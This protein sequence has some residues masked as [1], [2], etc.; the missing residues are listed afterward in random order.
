MIYIS[1]HDLIYII[2][3]YI[4]VNIIYIYVWIM[5]LYIF[6]W[7]LDILTWF[8][9]M[10]TWFIYIFTWF[11][12]IY[13]HASYHAYITL[14]IMCVHPLPQNRS[15]YL[16]ICPFICLSHIGHSYGLLYII[17]VGFLHIVARPICR[18]SVCL[19]ALTSGG[20]TLGS[21]PAWLG[22]VTSQAG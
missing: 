13:L 4:Y 11:I 20:P 9:D 22:L 10:F 6:T 1:I 8:I 17:I 18:L 7:F 14:A 15:A 12:Y 19:Q 2:Y 16:S 21:G 3:M 5:Y